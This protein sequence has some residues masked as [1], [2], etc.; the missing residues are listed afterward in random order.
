MQLQQEYYQL[1]SE[2]KKNITNLVMGMK[3]SPVPYFLLATQMLDE[4]EF[5][6]LEHA[7]LSIK[8]FSPTSKYTVE[9]AN[10]YE[11]EKLLA[12]GAVAPDIKLKQPDG[13]ELTLSSLRGKVVLLDFWASW[14]GPCRKEN[15]FNVKMYKDFKDKG[16]EIFGVSL[17]NDAGRWKGAI[18]KDS[19]IWKHVSDLGGWQSA[20]A[21]LYQVSSIPATYLLDKEGKIIAKGLRG[22]NLYAKLQ[23]VFA[24]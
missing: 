11:K 18:A 14:C 17:D 21:K 9:M 5:S 16:F 23:E 12:I 15:P 1:L 2:R 20:P 7:Y 22:E 10:R 6:L 4:I 8:A 3:Q 13:T 24:E 19:L